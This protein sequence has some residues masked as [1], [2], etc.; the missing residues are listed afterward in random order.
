M[1]GGS[2]SMPDMSLALQ[3]LATVIDR[4]LRIA[5][6]QPV[7]WALVMQLDNVA[8]YVS[9]ADRGDG[10]A[11][12]EDMLQHWRAEGAADTEGSDTMGRYGTRYGLS[13]KAL[14]E[15]AAQRGQEVTELRLQLA[16]VERER[17]EALG[18]AR[19]LEAAWNEHLS[20]LAA[21]LPGTPE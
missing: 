5:N 20:A 8:Q 17:D 19:M 14:A 9:N 11:L 2:S 13:D 4:S 1:S 3:L 15:V 6:R 12:V 21:G 10:L 16:I 7:A 18:R